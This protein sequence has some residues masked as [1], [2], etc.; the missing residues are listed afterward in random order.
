MTKMKL[1]TYILG[2]VIAPLCGQASTPRITAPVAQCP[3][4]FAIV[5]D[6]VTMER[7]APAI[8]AYRDAVES[9]GLSTWIVSSRWDHPADVR[10]A[11]KNLKQADPQLEGIVLVGD[12]PV[13]MVRNAQHMTTAFK[14]NEKT[15]PWPD[16]SVPSDR[17]YDDLHLVFEY[18]RPDST[19]ASR[20]YYKLSES[21]PQTLA[22]DL[23]SARI[24]Y[25]EAMGGDKYE[26]ISAYLNKA[27]DAKARNKDNKVDQ[28]FSYNGDSYNS[29]CLIVWLDEEK[30][31]RENFPLAFGRELGFK[32]WN[33]RMRHP[34]KHR[35]LDELRR[36]DLDV[37]MFHEHGLPTGQ[38]INGEEVCEGFD[39]RYRMLKSTLYNT[40]VQHAEH[41]DRDSL[42]MQMQQKRHLT[43]KFFSELDSARFWRD[44][45]IHYADEYIVTADFRACPRLSNPRFVM[46]DACYNGS[47][48]EN[49]YMAAPY[50]FN[51]GNTVTAQGNTRNVLQDRWTVEMLG[52][53]SHGVRVG[54]YNRMIASLEGHLIGDPTLRFAPIE[55]NTL[56]ADIT[57]RGTDRKYWMKQLE[58]PYADVQSLALRMLADTDTD[59]TMDELLLDVMKYSQFNTVR[60]EALKLLSRYGGENFVEGIRLGL[61]DPY[62]MVARQS[63]IYAGNNGDDSLLPALVKALVDDNERLRVQMSCNRAL[64]LYPSQKVQAAVDNYY[65]NANRKDASEE[66]ARLMRSL[67]R[68]FD[69]DARS[70]GVLMDKTVPEDKRIGAIRTVRNYPFHFHVADYLSVVADEENPTE[71]RTVMAEALGW[72]N[73][74][75]LRADIAGALSEIPT[76]GMADELKCEI[77]QTIKRLQ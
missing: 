58:S 42:A 55:D 10:T 1:T 6:D 68:T 25:P 29:D 20:F 48:H 11:I 27:A 17:F 18:L 53:L 43:D 45:S 74:S 64:Q 2:A 56:S 19:D 8:N 54:Q 13:A 33:F 57:L 71:V 31:Y 34:M 47:F 16:S 70:H 61:N 44:D 62:E 22:P 24:R 12:I 30:A 76:D 46:F 21:S 3:T 73:Q 14:M 5:V 28:V 60:M 59:G 39:D 23:Y 32:H 7:C 50:I 66:K 72:F 4:S 69:S 37:F 51:P 75:H 26:A 41:H 67:Q 65:A 38:L 49:D 15:F 35:L 63:A 40:V 52:L 36:E 77:E 9:D